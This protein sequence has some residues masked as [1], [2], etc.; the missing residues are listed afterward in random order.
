MNNKPKMYYMV[1][2]IASGSLLAKNGKWM[3]FSGFGTY[4][5]CYKVYR[6]KKACQNKVDLYNQFAPEG[7]P[8]V[9]MLE[10][11]NG[12][13][14]GFNNKPEMTYSDDNPDCDCQ[15]CVAGREKAEAMRKRDMAI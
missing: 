5:S 9:E 7:E 3:L 10:M 13:V 2:T 11:H 1:R 6:S 14:L 15:Y 8:R 12:L 4:G